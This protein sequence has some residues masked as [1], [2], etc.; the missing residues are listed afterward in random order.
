MM[1]SSRGNTYVIKKTI[2]DP[3][4][5]L[6]WLSDTTNLL[7]KG[8]FFILLKNKIH[9]ESP[10]IVLAMSFLVYYIKST[11]N[12][13]KKKISGITSDLEASVQ[14]KKQINT[15]E[16][17]WRNIPVKHLAIRELISKAHGEGQLITRK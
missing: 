12:K 11:I 9:T 15:M 4:G 5:L 14:Q 6:A 13:S 7:E 16:M 8:T 1:K 17:Q 2:R 10:W 3:A